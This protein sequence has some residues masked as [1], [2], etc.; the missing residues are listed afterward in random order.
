[1]SVDGLS[2]ETGMQSNGDVFCGKS[3]IISATPCTVAGSRVDSVAEL[4]RARA[5]ADVS[6]QCD[7]IYPQGTG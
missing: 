4:T 2:Q 6:Q 7:L 5:D 3:R 1:M